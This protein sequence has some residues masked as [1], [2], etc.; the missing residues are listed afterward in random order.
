[1]S[2]REKDREKMKERGEREDGEQMMG[3][4]HSALHFISIQALK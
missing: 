3:S 1:M 4:F 2:E